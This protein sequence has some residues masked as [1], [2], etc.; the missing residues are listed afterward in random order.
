MWLVAR[1]FLI[2]PIVVQTS[3][4]APTLRGVH[5]HVRCPK[6]S[7]GIVWGVDLAP[8]DAADVFCFQC[9]ASQSSVAERALVGG[10]RL[11]VDRNAFLLRAQRRWELAVLSDPEAPG[12]WLVKR[13]VGLP[14]ETISIR[15]GDLFSG[16]T[17]IKKSLAQFRALALSVY[18]PAD[19]PVDGPLSP[20]R[21]DEG[22]TQWERHMSGQ[23]VKFVRSPNATA[24]PA[25]QSA[26]F[27]W[28]VYRA[29]A[30]G[31]DAISDAQPY[32]QDRLRRPFPVSDV[33]LSCQTR[34]QGQ[35]A[36]AIRLPTASDVLLQ[37]DPSAGRAEMF[38]NGVSRHTAQYPVQAEGAKFSLA[39][40]FCDR[41]LLAEI[42]GQA[43][44]FDLEE[45]LTADAGQAVTGETGVLAIGARGLGGEVFDLHLAR[46][47]YYTTPAEHA[48]APWDQ[49][50]L[51]PNEYLMLGDNPQ[52]SRDG[53]YWRPAAVSGKSLLGKPFLVH[54]ASRPWRLGAW[55]IQV[56]D[57]ERI[58]YIPTAADE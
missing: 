56:P 13:I 35:G 2:A 39:V 45:I 6:C 46:D 37:L 20:W 8:F 23:G 49:V 31:A 58:R 57:F 12:R 17:R 3:S 55:V 28:L 26:Q 24:L 22:V 15:D 40:A 18:S 34:W 41:R 29:A 27:D 38:V 52:S 4:M 51:G 14:G 47:I 50:L 32:N 16:E 43:I 19:E 44:T 33:L 5:G 42:A 48:E 1:A 11:L 10:D 9:G 53:R 7:R 21:G 25:G 54:G 30:T 36:L